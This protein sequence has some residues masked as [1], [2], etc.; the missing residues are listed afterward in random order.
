MYRSCLD[1]EQLALLGEAPLMR[2]VRNIRKLFWEKG[3]TIEEEED[4]ETIAQLK[5]KGLTAAIAYLHSRGKPMFNPRLAR[6]KRIPIVGIDALFGYMIYGDVGDNPDILTLW[7]QQPSLGLPS[8]VNDLLALQR[9]R[10]QTTLLR[11][12]VLQR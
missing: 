7:V 12:G 5:G 2:V 8:K 10:G 9:Y 4:E 3:T 11:T 1:E 6:S